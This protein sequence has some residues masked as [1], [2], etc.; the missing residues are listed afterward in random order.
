MNKLAVLIS[1]SYRNFDVTWKT[2]EAILN[3]SGVEYE[4]FFHTWDANPN[5]DLN[6]LD[7]EFR[8]RFYLSIFQK[9]YTSFENDISKE[10]IE[11][12]FKFR[13]VQVDKLPE[14][15]LADKYNLGNYVS[16][17]RYQPLL[18]SCAMYFAIDLCRKEMLRDDSFSHFLRIRPDFVLDENR[19]AELFENDL[20]FFGQLLPTNEGLIGDQCFGG[21]IGCAVEVLDLMETLHEI[22]HSS[23]WDISKPMVLAEDVIR[24]GVLPLR[25]VL[26]IAYLQ[27][28]GAIVRPS[29]QGRKLSIKFI[30]Q[31]IAHNTN[32]FL[33]LKNRFL[34]RNRK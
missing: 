8:N 7:S 28:C 33:G 23:V 3:N 13:H 11:K 21:L 12:K 18:N 16:N 6:I 26:K 17:P 30:L 25:T 31:I 9:S 32:V 27:G 24:R 22:T 10:A 4:V 5:L 20:V 19:L 2:N 34:A 29:I 15:L 1:G 14:K